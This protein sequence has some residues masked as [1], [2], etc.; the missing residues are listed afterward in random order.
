VNL[1][2]AVL[3]WSAWAILGWGAP[4]VG[5]SRLG[6]S[7]VVG[8]RVGVRSL[9]FETAFDDEEI[10]TS[11]S[12]SVVIN[13]NEIRMRPSAVLGTVKVNCSKRRVNA[14]EDHS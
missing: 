1:G 3:G 2:W 12:I 10:L 14:L 13:T 6:A 9:I 8:S 7:R 5:G 4:R 11:R